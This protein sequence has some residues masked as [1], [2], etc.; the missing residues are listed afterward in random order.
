MAA[1]R[2]RVERFVGLRRK[3]GDYGPTSSVIA[4]DVP[5]RGLGGWGL[6]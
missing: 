3:S 4:T 2:R 5:N 6:G 1:S